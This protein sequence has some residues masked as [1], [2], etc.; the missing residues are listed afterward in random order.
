MLLCDDWPGFVFGSFVEEC[1]STTLMGLTAAA[2]CRA[3]KPR[4]TRASA[5]NLMR[6]PLSRVIAEVNPRRRG[7]RIK[8]ARASR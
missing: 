8:I 2:A 4:Q 3:R 5:G 6:N 1:C 7:D